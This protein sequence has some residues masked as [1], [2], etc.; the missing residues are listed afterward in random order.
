MTGSPSDGML[1][2]VER[3]FHVGAVGTLSDAELLDR[4]V[5]GRDR[6]GTA[7]FEELVVRHG[8]MVLR[9][10]RNIL[11]NGHD[12]EDAFQ[13]VFLVLANRAAY[14]RQ[15]RSVASWLFGV[16]QRAAWRNQRSTARRT[17]LHQTVAE[18]FSERAIP[19]DN[20]SDWQTLHEEINALPERFR[21]PV[22]LCYLQGLSY[23]AAAGQL[24]LTNSSLRGRLARARERLRLRLT[25]RGVAVPAGLLAAGTASE[26]QA[27]VPLILQHSTVR[28]ALGFVAGNTAVVLARGVLTSM[29][30]NRAKIATALLLLGIGSSYWAWRSL[31][32]TSARVG[33]LATNQ[34]AGNRASPS[35]KVRP[36]AHAASYRFM[37]SVRVEGTGE[38]VPGAKLTLLLGDMT[39][40]NSPERILSVT[41]SKDGQ[42][43]A[44][45][46]PGQTAAFELVAPVGYWVPSS[47]SRNE[48][49]VLSP[50][51]PTRRQDYVVRRGVVWPFRLTV[52]ADKKPLREGS[53]N[54]SISDAAVRNEVD[55]SGLAR[56]TLP[57][58]GGSV[59]V[60]AWA[61]RSF[62]RRY[63]SAPP[64]MIP[65]EWA[66]GFRPDAIKNIERREARFRLT[67]SAGHI[68]TIGESQRA[69]LK[70]DGQRATEPAPG[71]VEP[72]VTDGKLVISV[73]LFEPETAPAGD[74][75]GQVID[76]A[77]RP[78]Q[79]ALVAPA[80][81]IH[82]GKR[83]SGSFPDDGQNQAST[84]RDGQF[85]IRE[86]RCPV[87]YG[88]TATFSLV[89][90][91]EGFAG[92]ETA[93]LSAQPGNA[94]STRS[95]ETIRLDRGVK[96]KGLVVDPDGR[97]AAGVWILPV[98]N[99]ALRGRF[100]RSDAAGKFTISDLPKGLV[101]LSFEFGKAMA[102]GKHLAD[103]ADDEIKVQLRL[104]HDAPAPTKPARAK[105]PDP[106][107]LGSPAPPLQVAGWTDG[108]S[109]SLADYRGKVV[110]L[111]FWGIWCSACVNGMPN[112]E[113]FKQKYEPRGVF[114]L[115]IHTP[116]EELDKI[117]RFLHVKRSSLVSA[118]DANRGP[119][120]NSD[121]GVTAGRYGVKAYPTV[122]IIDRDGKIV[123]HSGIGTKEGVAAMKRLG[124]EMGI[125]EATMTKEQFERLHE[126]FFSREIERVLDR[127]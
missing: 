96:L 118:L 65:L 62:Q 61:E 97:P 26:A 100:T 66:V 35:P 88:R 57:S 126:A 93:E 87:L 2:Q 31:A 36:P 25:R 71:R 110:F 95:L 10:C 124:I 41:S 18:R 8:P 54:A 101:E 5:A 44:D 17:A 47:Q 7:A 32:A 67:D 11:R 79:G 40:S 49:F 43:V 113:R 90:R 19:P 114:F 21:A 74:I 3:L 106:S 120:D 22:V 48:S 58:E 23:D 107:A 82:E 92:V 27:A 6:G 13:A 121:D 12:A 81:H 115:S 102:S 68:A 15:S 89:V 85:V 30:W 39:G 122:V 50:E 105:A 1:R 16:A 53:V 91:K 63:S 80:F 52:G 28:I 69:I 125:E 78:I 4:F 76:E 34:A 56:L 60:A 104:S 75:T 55:E 111:D 29:F 86:I 14:I 9:I 46:P 70:N 38:P 20:D 77:G 127:Q 109:H 73:N 99:F 59:D 84:D 117:R 45:L 64:V 116:G 98:G 108:Q 42:L 72:I 33:T 123:Y 24:G 83:G 51:Q 103:G 94:S 112:L 37:G 119:N